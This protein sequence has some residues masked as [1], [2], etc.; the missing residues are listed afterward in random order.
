[1]FY[2]PGK[3]PSLTVLDLFALFSVTGVSLGSPG[4][5][6]PVFDFFKVALG[7]LLICQP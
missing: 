3:P 2:F 7:V 5:P 6:G 1:M 4:W